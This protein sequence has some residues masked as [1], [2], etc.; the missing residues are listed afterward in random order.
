L[1]V[2]ESQAKLKKEDLAADVGCEG[3]LPDTAEQVK[4]GLEDGDD[5]D[6]E[7]VQLLG[8]QST[9]DTDGENAEEVTMEARD[10]C[11]A[12]L[13]W[14]GDLKEARG[15]FNKGVSQIVGKERPEGRLI[16]ARMIRRR[17]GDVI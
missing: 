16:S 5:A 17:K 13:A 3:E 15:L 8:I 12:N 6:N 11:P 14:H 1:D 4:R 7:T 10:W 2:E 9:E